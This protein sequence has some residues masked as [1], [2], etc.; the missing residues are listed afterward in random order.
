MSNE[1]ESAYEHGRRESDNHSGLERH[2]SSIG[3]AIT[4]LV[5]GWVSTSIMSQTES[6][7]VLSNKVMHVKEMIE[8]AASDR[9]TGSQATTDKLMVKLQ[10]DAMNKR[11][12]HV[13]G[14]HKDHELHKRG[15]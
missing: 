10:L 4:V 8:T 15:K 6:I 12:D 9:Y 2:L 7:A 13:E 14:E 5:L 11:L 1:T 3:V